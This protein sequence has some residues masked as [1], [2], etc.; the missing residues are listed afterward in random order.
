[1][2]RVTFYDVRKYVFPADVVQCSEC[3]ALV[4]K[5]DAST[6]HRWH[7]ALAVGTGSKISGSSTPRP[8]VPPRLVNG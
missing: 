2:S 4:L 3:A 1:M 8:S 6:H 7:D 5:S